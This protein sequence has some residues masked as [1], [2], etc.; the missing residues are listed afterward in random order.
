M[1]S[2]GRSLIEDWWCAHK[3]KVTR[4]LWYWTKIKDSCS[5]LLI[6]EEASL[7]WTSIKLIP[8][9]ISSMVQRGSL[10]QRTRQI[11]WDEEEDTAAKL[12][13]KRRLLLRTTGG[14]SNNN[15]T[16]AAKQFLNYVLVPTHWTPQLWFPY[17]LSLF[18][19]LWNPHR[20]D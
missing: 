8:L 12:W 11:D 5:N 9:R 2:H 19:L 13:R 17:C 1:D 20:S 3:K 16:S 4:Y 10:G 6:F 18:D 14:D 15:Y 7:R